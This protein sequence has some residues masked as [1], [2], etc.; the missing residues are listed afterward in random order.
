MNILKIIAKKRD[1]LELSKEEIEYF[2]REYT[3]GNI[4]ASKYCP[5]CAII[6]QRVKTKERVR[7]WREKQKS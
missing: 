4:A 3:N 5:E 6:I 1:A 2:I 7:R